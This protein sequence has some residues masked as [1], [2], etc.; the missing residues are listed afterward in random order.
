[1]ADATTILSPNYFGTAA[2]TKLAPTTN[3]TSS[4]KG[5]FTT[6]APAASASTEVAAALITGTTTTSPTASGTQI[7]SGGVHNLPRFLENWGSNTVAIRGSLVSM[8]SS[9]I[10]TA[11]WSISY[12]QPPIRRW[13]FDQTFANGKYPPICPQ[14]ISYRRVDFSYILNAAQYTTKVNAL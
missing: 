11:D 13:G 14:V 8:F 10:Q 6:A 9:R 4:A 3:V 12:Y 7:F 2:G 1:M 5:S